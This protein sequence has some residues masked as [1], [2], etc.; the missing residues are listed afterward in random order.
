MRGRELFTKTKYILNGCAN[1]MRLL[2]P[3][4]FLRLLLVFVRNIPT[5]MGIA[6]RYIIL[7]ALAQRCGDNVAIFESV[8]GYQWDKLCLG[9]HVSIHPLCYIDASGGLYIG[10]DVSIAHNVTIMTSE[11]RFSELQIATRDQISILA[12]VIIGND[13]WIGAGV[14]ILAGVTIGNHV[15]IGAGAVVTRDIPSHSLAVGIPARVVKE[16]KKE[17]SDGPSA[18][19]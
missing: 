14:R 9:D 10:S 19:I 17:I 11:H 1:L 2:L 5:K 6:I 13:V 7:S 16:I 4:P 12:P 18:A 8:Y 3:K 15:V